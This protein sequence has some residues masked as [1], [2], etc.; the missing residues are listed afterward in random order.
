MHIYVLFQHCIMFHGE[1]KKRENCIL[2]GQIGKT[3]KKNFSFWGKKITAS[4]EK[5]G[6]A[7]YK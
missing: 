4:G 7:K 5:L 2:K 3:L 6:G 1:T